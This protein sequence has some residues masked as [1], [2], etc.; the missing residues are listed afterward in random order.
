MNGC[1]DTKVKVWMDYIYAK[2]AGAKPVFPPKPMTEAKEELL[3][4]LHQSPQAAGYCESRWTLELIQQAC[5][6][7][8]L[9]TESGVWRLLQRLGIVK[10]QG[11]LALHS[12]DVNY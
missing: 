11:R 10:K 6:W 3:E 4:I 8:N 2:D 7:L 5:S 12:P 1:I 9:K